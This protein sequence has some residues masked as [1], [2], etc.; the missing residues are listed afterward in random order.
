[1]ALAALIVAGDTGHAADHELMATL[2]I[3]LNG[4]ENANGTARVM[5][6]DARQFL[7][8]GGRRQSAPVQDGR[9][10]VIFHQVPPGRYAI[11]AYHD[12]NGNRKLDT[13]LFGV[14]KEP[15]GF[16]NDARNPFGPPRFDDAKFMVSGEALTL[17]ITVK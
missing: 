7:K 11:Q 14:P 15:Y 16:S 9:A 17:T 10:T 6:V 5:L 1:M 2:T 8:S 4:F 13:G 12:K 3:E